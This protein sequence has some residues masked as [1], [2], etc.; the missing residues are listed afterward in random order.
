M[1][2]KCRQYDKKILTEIYVL[3]LIDLGKYEQGL[4]NL[5]IRATKL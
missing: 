1:S 4:Y 2:D 3:F 5:P